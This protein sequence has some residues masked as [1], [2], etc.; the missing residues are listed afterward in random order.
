MTFLEQV[1]GTHNERLHSLGALALMTSLIVFLCLMPL[2]KIEGL[3]VFY[4]FGTGCCLVGIATTRN[5]WTRWRTGED[6]LILLR[7]RG[8]EGREHEASLH[9]MGRSIH[10]KG[11]IAHVDVGVFTITAITPDTPPP[12]GSA[13]KRG[14]QIFRAV[15]WAACSSL[16][17][18]S[19]FGLSVLAYGMWLM[20]IVFRYM[21]SNA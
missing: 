10:W 21:M 16:I 11:R 6:T 9:L 4:L 18:Q 12:T 19:I 2:T 20:L 17:F 13:F 3:V 8:D 7:K 5:S 15:Y 14:Y 1:W